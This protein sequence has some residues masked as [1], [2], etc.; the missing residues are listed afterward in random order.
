LTD[1]K[2]KVSRVESGMSSTIH[3]VV[4]RFSRYDDGKTILE[5][6][7]ANKDYS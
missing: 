6:Y 3:A 4:V 1:T 2:I 5:Y 7:T